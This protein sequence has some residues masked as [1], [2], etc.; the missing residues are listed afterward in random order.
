MI[1]SLGHDICGMGSSGT[2]GRIRCREL[3]ERN[4]A[5]L[6][7]NRCHARQSSERCV[8]SLYRIM[9]FG[10]NREGRLMGFRK[11]NKY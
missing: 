10:L 7:G 2:V 4:I 5:K 11:V 3:V 6:Y 9:Q 8:G 1:S